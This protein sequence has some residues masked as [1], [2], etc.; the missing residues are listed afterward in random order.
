MHPS[1]KNVIARILFLPLTF[2]H[3]SAPHYSCLMS[4]LALTVGC[5]SSC[6]FQMSVSVLFLIEMLAGL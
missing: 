1:Y 5:I 6:I 4:P 3:V 2:R